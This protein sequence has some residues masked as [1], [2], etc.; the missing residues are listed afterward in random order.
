MSAATTYNYSIG[1]TTGTSTCVKVQR[2]D[3]RGVAGVEDNGVFSATD[4][5]VVLWDGPSVAAA[6]YGA[7]DGTNTVPGRTSQ[8]FYVN[9][10][11]GKRVQ[12]NPIDGET[13]QHFEARV[14]FSDE[15]F[16]G[17][18]PLDLPPDITWSFQEDGKTPYLLDFNPSGPKA[19][20]NSAGELFDYLQRDNGTILVT[21]KR[22]VAPTDTNPQLAFN[23]ASYVP[24]GSTTPGVPVTNQ[25]GFT[26][27]GVS[28]AVGL[29]KF[30]GVQISALQQSNQVLYRSVSYTLG[31]KQSGWTD[32]VD[33]R[34]Y[35]QAATIGG[36]KMLMDIVQGNPPV[37]PQQ[38]WPLSSGKAKPNVTDKPDTLTFYPYPQAPFA[39][40][41]FT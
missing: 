38:P 5:Y 12:I 31:I 1:S 13:R 8:H 30:K 35:H 37:K 18:S 15:L 16:L 36:N 25:D 2:Q 29:A 4:Y 19:V 40:F 34:G 9:Y 10:L 6:C 26:I 28:V 20:A 22:N 32:V 41:S 3:H 7:T 24:S 39:P 23:Y 14:E 27:D 17:A 11:F 21:F 33:D